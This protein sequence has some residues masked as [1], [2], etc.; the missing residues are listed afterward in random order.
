[1]RKCVFKSLTVCLYRE[2]HAVFESRRHHQL[3][4]LASDAV[5]SLLFG[6]AAMHQD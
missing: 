4:S 6:L 2:S 5:R 1:M 3:R